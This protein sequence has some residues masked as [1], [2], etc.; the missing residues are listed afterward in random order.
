MAQQALLSCE[1]IEGARA[2][3]PA[4]RKKHQGTSL[5]AFI[6]S[7]AFT[8]FHMPIYNFFSYTFDDSTLICTSQNGIISLRE[9]PN[10]GY[11]RQRYSC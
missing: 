6:R 2:G 3:F 5:C 1:L 7:V 4:W 10:L 11:K 9:T 8:H